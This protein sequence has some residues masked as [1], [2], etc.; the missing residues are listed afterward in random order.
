MTKHSLAISSSD[1]KT[2]FKVMKVLIADG[3]E[4]V[5]E[6]LT[7]LIDK[8]LDMTVT[9]YAENGLD[10]LFK[11]K[12]LEPDFVI[13]DT[14]LN[15]LRGFDAVPLIHEAAPKT[16]IIIFS[17]NKNDEYIHK[18]FHS[19][20][21]AYVLK[22]SPIKDILDSIRA[23]NRGERFVSPLIKKRVIDT[24]NDA[25]ENGR[26]ECR[27]DLLT[28]QEQQVFRMIVEGYS[29]GEIAEKFSIT[30][31]K[32][33]FFRK[34]IADKIQMHDIESMQRYAVEIGIIAPMCWKEHFFDVLPRDIF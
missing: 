14:E 4:I 30:E 34:C 25:V 8:Q 28:N 2:N 12:S 15:V 7:R 24:Y 31:H 20:A 16:K 10:A 33:Y 23:A 19:G 18:S 21:S 32:I 5:R 6:G 13:M 11:T 26:Q 1:L 29:L 22:L 9:G 17:M 3:H 27:Y